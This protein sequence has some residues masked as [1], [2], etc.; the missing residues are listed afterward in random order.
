[1]VLTPDATTVLRHAVALVNSAPT[2]GDTSVE[3]LPTLASL[4]AFFDEWRWTGARPRTPADLEAVRA[5]REDLRGL[6]NLADD[7]EEL[8]ERVNAMLAQHHALPQLERHDDLDWH[9]HAT[10]ADAPFAA[11]IA[12]ETAMAFVDVIR[13][14]ETGRIK[15][16]V[17]ADCESVLVDLSRNRS[18]MFCEGTC[19]TRTHV[20]A[21]RARKA[22]E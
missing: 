3:D 5:V 11:R 17:A 8:V 13:A 4:A 19:A 21:Y 16:C 20:A 7:E 22:V 15:V 12:V 18:R 2:L 1:M 10:P 9:I 14:G 6:W